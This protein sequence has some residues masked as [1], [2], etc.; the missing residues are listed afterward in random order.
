MQ[1]QKKEY[2]ITTYLR[3]RFRMLE[4]E[5]DPACA[6]YSTLSSASTE[7]RDAFL[8]SS[9]LPESV[10]RFLNQL[11]RKINILLVR[12][13]NASLE[14][15]FPHTMEIN[16]I[17]AAELKFTTALPLAPGDWLEIIINLGQQG[18]QTASGIGRVEK[19]RTGKNG[20]SVFSFTF[21]R[22]AE[23]EREKIFRFVFSEERKLLRETRL[24]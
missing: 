15:D 22:L 17:S 8:A 12:S 3:A 11:D 20:S 9:Q 19:R 24:E 18:L 21:I 1:E 4:G 10:I 14:Q 6:S 7:T 23:E 5:D 13:L 16:A 2:S